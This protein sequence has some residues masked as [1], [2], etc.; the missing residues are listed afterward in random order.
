M[1]KKIKDENGK[2]YVQK[3]PFYKRIWFWILVVFIV[4]GIGGNLGDKKNNTKSAS[5]S[6]SSETSSSSSNET[7]KTK[8][9]S[10]LTLNKGTFMTD[11]DGVATIT[12]TTN[13]GATVVVGLVHTATA[14]ADGKFKI[15]YDLS[16]AKKKTVNVSVSA[17][18]KKTTVHNI[19]ITPSNQFIASKASK[20]SS[21][22]KATS[23]KRIYK[24]GE[25][26][27][28]GTMQYTVNN[29]STAKSVG[30]SALPSTA[31]DTYLVADLTVKN[32]G[33]KSVTVDS[34][35]FK[36][37]DGKKEFKADAGGSMSANQD[38]S[39]TIT[40]SFFEQELNPGVQMQGKIVFDISAA[41]ANS[42]ANQL[43]V[44][45]GAFGTQTAM[46]ALH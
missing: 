46:I 6:S 40:N 42:Q 44:Q 24:I 15:T 32:N 39:G 34:S 19:V 37:I 41:Q 20:D 38:E 29:I 16:S 36:L 45:T 1:A 26:V 9:T 12:G 2:T 4:I 22:S 21:N 30:P 31:K 17:K 10:K 33:N 18:N 7:K 13:P 28:V 27:T 5:N 8:E 35:F 11:Q 25:Q 23:S 43:Q 14:G 3:K